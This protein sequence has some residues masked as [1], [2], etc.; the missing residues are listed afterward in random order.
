ML[1]GFMSS[2]ERNRMHAKMTRDRKKNFIA[3]IEKT[4][5][6]LER[7]NQKMRD[8]LNKVGAQEQVV[9]ATVSPMTSPGIAVN[10]V[11]EKKT[12]TPAEAASHAFELTPAAPLPVTHTAVF[13]SFGAVFKKE[14]KEPPRQEPALKPE[15]DTPPKRQKVAHGFSLDG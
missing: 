1:F 11:A 15:Q 13:A 10:K 12:E 8:V 7:D 9:A 6:H 5:K 2:R 3:T 14:F 4:I